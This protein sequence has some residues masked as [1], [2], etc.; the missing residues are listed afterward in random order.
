MAPIPRR[1]QLPPTTPNEELP[2]PSPRPSHAQPSP[3]PSSSGAD[4]TL[5]RTTSHPGF[6]KLRDVTTPS[7]LDFGKATYRAP[8][9]LDAESNYFHV[10]PRAVEV[11]SDETGS[12]GQDVDWRM[13][14]PDDIVPQVGALQAGEHQPIPRLQRLQRAAI[15]NEVNRIRQQNDDEAAGQNWD[16]NMPNND[17]ADMVE[18]GE[19]DMD[20]LLEGVLTLLRR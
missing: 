13:G 16:V 20:G 19:D 6:S 7:P 2:P 15:A 4:L 18:G 17:E 11:D 8:E 14:R 10:A 9:D 12:D 1:P 3:L 5:E